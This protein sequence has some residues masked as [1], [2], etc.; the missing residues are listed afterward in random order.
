MFLFGPFIVGGTIGGGRTPLGPNGTLC[1]QNG[2]PITTQD[3]QFILIETLANLAADIILTEAGEV[4][5]TENGYVL[6][7]E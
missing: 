7:F 3:H 4:L 5:T 1:L 6:R 2:E